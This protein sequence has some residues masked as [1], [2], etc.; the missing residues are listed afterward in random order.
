MADFMINSVSYQSKVMDGEM[1]MLISR[2]LL[3]TFTALIGVADSLATSGDTED[4]TPNGRISS[5]IMPV[6]REL[7]KLSDADT[8]FIVDS[9][10]SLTTRR[11]GTGTGW[12]GVIQGG[13]I[14]DKADAAFATRAT[15]AWHVLSEAFADMLG[16]LG[17]DLAALRGMTPLGLA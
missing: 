11:V 2:R 3:P 16:S 14:Q 4:D 17:V 5:A 9:C 13:V 15:I 6:A 7:A 10:M 1:Q 12:V 8:R